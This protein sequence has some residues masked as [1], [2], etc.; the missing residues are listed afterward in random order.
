MNNVQRLRELATRSPKWDISHQALGNSEE[1]ISRVNGND[2][3]EGKRP[4]EHSTADTHETHMQ[5]GLHRCAPDWVL[6]ACF[7]LFSNKKESG[8]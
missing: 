5:R 1:K 3:H 4:S 8:K 2:R 6:D 7:I